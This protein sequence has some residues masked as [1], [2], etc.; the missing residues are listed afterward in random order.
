MIYLLKE[1]R[2]ESNNA[3]NQLKMNT[4]SPAEMFV[5]PSA[6][7]VERAPMPIDGK[8]EYNQKNEEHQIYSSMSKKIKKKNVGKKKIN[9]VC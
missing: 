5:L 8:T 6:S 7:R 1:K 9:N 3:N 2:K 4:F